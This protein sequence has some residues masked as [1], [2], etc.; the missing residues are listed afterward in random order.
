MLEQPERITPRHRGVLG[1][2]TNQDYAGT[3]S[4]QLHDAPHIMHPEQARLVDQNHL[5]ANLFL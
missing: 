5:P 2:I 1:G 3:I 4:R